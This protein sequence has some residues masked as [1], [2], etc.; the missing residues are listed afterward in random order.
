MG[1][2]W[3]RVSCH[4]NRIFIAAG[5]SPIECVQCHAIKNKIK[6]RALDKVKKFT[7]CKRQI[8]KTVIQV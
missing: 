6:N 5:V 2:D 1:G 3:K 8:K 4:E 7:Y